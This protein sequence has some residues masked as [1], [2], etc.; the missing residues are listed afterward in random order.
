MG[1]TT[2]CTY[3]KQVMLARPSGVS[4]IRADF[5]ES[6]DANAVAVD[7]MQLEKLN[8][9]RVGILFGLINSKLCT[10]LERA[11]YLFGLDYTPCRRAVG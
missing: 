11:K 10:I 4:D 9:L 6:M 7:L 1:A 5:A 8:R 3:Y 2:D